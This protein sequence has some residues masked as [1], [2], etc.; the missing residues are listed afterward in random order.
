[1]RFHSLYHTPN[2][3]LIILVLFISG[4]CAV[5]PVNVQTQPSEVDLIKQAQRAEN[6]GKYEQAAQNYLQAAKITGTATYQLQ[7]VAALLRGNFMEQARQI[8]NVIEE[9]KLAGELK[10]RWLILAS[11]IALAD[12][13][14][15]AALDLLKTVALDQAPPELAA[16][17]HDIRAQAYL[18]VSKFLDAAREQVK[19][20]SLLP[21]TDTDKIN[22]NQQAIWQTLQRLTG[23]AL[24]QAQVAP[25]P[26]TFSGWLVLA[27]I[28]KQSHEQPLDVKS[29]V[30]DWQMEY[31][32]HPA[33]DNILNSL[34]ARQKEEIQ[35]PSHIALLLPHSG[36]YASAAAALRNGFLSAHYN[37]SNQSYRPVIQIYDVGPNA[38]EIDAVYSQ[39][40]EDGADFIV[41]PLRKKSVN[42]L[43]RNLRV[44]VPTLTLNYSEMP[45][46]STTNIYQFGLAPEDEA[47]QVAERA[48][49]DGHNQAIALI[50]EGAWGERVL[51]AFRNDWDLL[52]G[53]LLEYQFY[54]PEKNDFSPQ[55]QALLNL[56]ESRQRHKQLQRILQTTLEFEPRRRQDSDFVFMA[57]FPRQARLLRPQLKF[58]YASRLPVYATS[59]IYT[60]H[61]D[62]NADRDM[63]GVIFTDIPWVLNDRRTPLPLK[64][65]VMALWPKSVKQYT[66]FYALGIDAYDI[67]PS[68]STMKNYRY[69][70]YHGQTGIL[71][72]GINNRIFRETSWAR[73][74]KGVPVPY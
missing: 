69:E 8:L 38:E 2:L 51:E 25:A 35:R 34:L 20:E 7:A 50:P 21:P 47:R 70:R 41:G 72:L 61:I 54:P 23:S 58:H 6:Q 53:T 62:K 17:V 43:T 74:K 9:Q 13:L 22:E 31:P 29:L 39:A 11:R 73:F 16:E 42:Q 14:P 64:Q 66:R 65:K 12:N 59:H 33:S 68:L 48:W 28:A 10:I 56:D 46:R 44:P 27:Q 15:R 5:K 45:N 32:H 19:R 18:R 52:G 30:Q 26:D 4:G 63:D 55:I 3:I 37:R 40:V 36:P 67:I 60:G 49:L 1:M 24:I 71:H 57:A